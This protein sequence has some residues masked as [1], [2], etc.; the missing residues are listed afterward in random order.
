MSKPLPAYLKT[1]PDGKIRCAS[2]IE[3]PDFQHY[4]DCEFGR[5]VADDRR[6]FEKICVETFGAGLNFLMQLKRRNAFRAAF[7]NFE[8]DVV[9]A[10]PAGKTVT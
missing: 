6:I 5:P 3:D 7:D 9:A 8:I 2:Q 1:L 10:Y 4:H